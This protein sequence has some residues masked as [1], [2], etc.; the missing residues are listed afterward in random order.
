MEEYIN[1]LSKQAGEAE[2][3]RRK[4]KLIQGRQKMQYGPLPQE[5][6]MTLL[7]KKSSKRDTK[8]RRTV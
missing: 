4:W 6:K 2:N 3:P 7:N 1:D 8:R 5:L